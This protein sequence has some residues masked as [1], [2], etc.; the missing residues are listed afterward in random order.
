[1]FFPE[2][3]LKE[4]KKKKRKEKGRVNCRQCECLFSSTLYFSHLRVFL[5]HTGH[6]SN[7]VPDGHARSKYPCCVLGDQHQRERRRGRE[8]AREAPPEALVAGRPCRAQCV[9]LQRQRG[10]RR[11]KRD[12][13]ARPPDAQQRAQHRQAPAAQ[14]REGAPRVDRRG[15]ASPHQARPQGHQRRPLLCSN[16]HIRHCDAL[17]AYNAQDASC[18]KGRER[19]RWRCF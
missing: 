6:C 1:M 11:G 8:E 12:S 9:T 17:C 19:A 13:P 5:S 2:F 14:R 10:G 18:S 16:S 3:L 15:R 4:R 7:Q